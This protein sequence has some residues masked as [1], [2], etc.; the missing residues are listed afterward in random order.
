M[1]PIPH[2]RAQA[3][4]VAAIAAA[5]GFIALAGFQLALALGAPFGH[6]AWGGSTAHLSAAQRVGSAFAVVLWIGAAATVLRRVGLIAR[7]RAVAVV[8]WATWS[9]AGLCAISAVANLASDSRW[10]KPSSGRV[11]PYWRCSAQSPRSGHGSISAA[12]NTGHL[13]SVALG[14][15]GRASRA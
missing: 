5:A 15:L 2:K 1:P 13:T 9:I 6:A 14:G 11:R 7:P 3:G 4:R 10:E 12:R 8:R